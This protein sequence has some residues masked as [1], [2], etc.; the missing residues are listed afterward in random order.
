VIPLCRPQG[1]APGR[2]SVGA[3]GSYPTRVLKGVGW[4]R[5]EARQ[6]AGFELL[7]ERFR[8]PLY[9]FV[10]GM[11]LDAGVAE[12]LTLKA[13]DRAYAARESYSDE[14]SASAWLH[15]FAVRLSMAHLRR[16]RLARLLPWRRLS[17]RRAERR[18]SGVE[19]ALGSLNPDLRAVALLSLY[20]RLSIPEMAAILTIQ[21]ETAAWRLDAATEGMT[22]AL[23]QRPRLEVAWPR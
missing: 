20:A 7:Y 10:R 18:G 22:A 16:R 21:E 1:P 13:F 23:S 5:S 14:L 2:L 17:G 19:L 12:E 4:G 9:R 11:V 15:G 3:P 8:L 6:S